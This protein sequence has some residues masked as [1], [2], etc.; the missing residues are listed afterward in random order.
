M[1]LRAAD[2]GHNS[3][4]LYSDLLFN[5][6]ILFVLIV[7]YLVVRMDDGMRKDKQ[8]Q[9]SNDERARAAEKRAADSERG[10]VDAQQR[11]TEA[12]SKAELAG[13]KVAALEGAARD[14]AEREKAAEREVA[15]LSS[16]I[17]VAVKG[18]RFGTPVG[19]T[20]VLVAFDCST[21]PPQTVLVNPSAFESWDTRV[22]E[23]DADRRKRIA[24][25]L[26]GAIDEAPRFSGEDLQC[27]F[28]A[29][30]L[31]F[32]SEDGGLHI[33]SQP[34]ATWVASGW[35]HKDG[36]IDL[37]KV[38]A[39]LLLHAGNDAERLKAVNDANRAQVVHDVQTVYDN[40]LES[41]VEQL[42]AKS[43]QSATRSIT[44]LHFSAAADR[45]FVLVGGTRH[46][47]SDFK[48]MVSWFGD[49]GVVLQFEPANA[50]PPEYVKNLLK[51]G[52]FTDS[53]PDSEELGR[54]RGSIA[55]FQRP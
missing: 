20:R 52:G 25:D 50:D 22:N 35:E 44:V 28:T 6:L 21:A 26:H 27:F 30:E 38:G 40:T 5:L 34:D 9:A 39:Y 10:A 33:F 46:R 18:N 1:K 37:D 54:L 24:G 32:C 47:L 11:I 41:G 16:Q 23:N 15:A 3:Y 51:D 17:R 43:R 53:V 49:G 4:V 55:P 13:A 48:A 8:S 36:T 31:G 14:E 7:L 2:D 12:E 19:K 29:L 42:R 45:D